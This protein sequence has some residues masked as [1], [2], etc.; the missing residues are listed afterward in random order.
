MAKLT[1]SARKSLPR[2]DF[3]LPATRGKGGKNAA[4]RG[5]YPMPNASHA[6]AAIRDSKH[7]ENVGNITAGQRSQIVRKADRKLGK[8]RGKSLGD[9][10]G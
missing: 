8:R 1:T 3:G 6:R 10:F 9:E 7:A 4:G 5:S 2:S